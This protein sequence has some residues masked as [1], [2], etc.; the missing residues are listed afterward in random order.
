MFEFKKK[1]TLDYSFDETKIQKT[2]LR[3][4]TINYIKNDSCIGT[5]LKNG[6]YWEKMDV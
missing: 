5:C 2:N 1:T 3:N 4:I 6:Y